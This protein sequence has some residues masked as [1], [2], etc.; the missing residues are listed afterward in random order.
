[1]RLLRRK[2]S[3]QIYIIN[4]IAGKDEKDDIRAIEKLLW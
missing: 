4:N 2:E 3:N 1:M